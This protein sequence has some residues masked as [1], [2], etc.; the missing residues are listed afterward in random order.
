MTAAQFERLAPSEAEALLCARFRALAAWGCP[1]D[2]ALVLASRVDIE[3]CEAIS[4]L[5]RG[6]PPVLVPELLS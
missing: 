3:V 5:R 6:C 4:L 2:D 1:P